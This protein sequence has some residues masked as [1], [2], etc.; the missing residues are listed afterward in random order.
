MMVFQSTVGGRI[1]MDVVETP[2]AVLSYHNGEL[3]SGPI[4]VDLIWYGNFSSTQRAIV[5]D[6][7]TSLSS[8]HHLKKEPK[9]VGAWWETTEKY[10]KQLGKKSPSP[11]IPKLSLGGEMLDESYS[12]GK[13][14]TSAAIASFATS[15]IVGGGGRKS[16]IKVVLTSS[17]VN[18]DGFC[19][20][21]CGT[22]GSTTASDS[23]GKH[24]YI[25]VG[26]S[27]TQCPGHCAW[28]FHQPI[29]GPQSPPLV[30][31]NGDVGIDGMVINLAGLLASTVTNPF[32]NGYFQ[33]ETAPLE[34]ASAC[35]GVYSSGAYPGYAGNLLVDYT[36]GG[37][38][39]AEGD[40][41]RK[42]LLPAVLDPTTKTC[43]TL[44]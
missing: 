6:F 7:V 21:R 27:V 33:N 40:N 31:P 16:T 39:N 22:H 38:Y 41:G 29:Y 37:S 12:L 44:H 5:S 36:T 11:V 43:S 30:A 25:W 28:P 18:V 14:L 3:L 42:F 35:S 1:L 15:N 19:M 34:V 2:A 9:T 13:Q 26:N 8:D 20:S 17:D 10:Y 4:S 23:G 32:G 24:A